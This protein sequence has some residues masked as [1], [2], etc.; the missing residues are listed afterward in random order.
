MA[1]KMVIRSI[2]FCNMH[3][4]TARFFVQSVQAGVRRENSQDYRITGKNYG[5]Y[6]G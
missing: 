1:W 5:E 4:P 6:Y 3:L 2:Y